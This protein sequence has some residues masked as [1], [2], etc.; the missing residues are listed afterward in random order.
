[1]DPQH[2]EGLN[3]RPVLAVDLPCSRC[4]YNLRG[5]AGDPVRCPECGALTPVLAIVVTPADIRSHQRR[6]ESALAFTAAAALMA[7]PIAWCLLLLCNFPN[8][9]FYMAALMVAAVGLQAAHAG[10]YRLR[11]LC[12]DRGIAARTLRRLFWHMPGLLLL[13]LLPFV[14]LW[15]YAALAPAR[16][17]TEVMLN[18]MLLG[19]VVALGI[20][21]LVVARIVRPHY[22]RLRE[23]LPALG[24]DHVRTRVLAEKSAQQEARSRWLNP[25]SAWRS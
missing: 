16:L 8:P 5:L 7:L 6:V 11:K 1:M 2:S 4:R 17:Y 10:I 12:G 14:A 23:S 18:R 3:E 22:A 21:V 15:T 19:A 25:E 24:E 9:C 20:S 13:V